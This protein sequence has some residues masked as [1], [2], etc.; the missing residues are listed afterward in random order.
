[1]GKLILIRHGHTPLNAAG[2]EERLRGWLDIPLDEQG[3]QEAV[4][5]AQRIAHYRVT[6]IYS[7]DLRR[8]RQT[9]EIV[10]K[11]TKASVT[12]TD[13]LR[14]WNLGIFAGQKLREIIPFLNQLNQ[15]PDLP[16]PS[17]ESFYEFYG[18]YTR[19][20]TELLNLAEQSSGYVVAVTHVR[21]LLAT[22]TIL[23]H[24][25][26]S[27]VPVSGGPRTG[28]LV[29]VEKEGGTWKMRESAA[30]ATAPLSFDFKSNFEWSH[31]LTVS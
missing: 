26:R 24:G 28:T 14:P 27:R 17:G 6:A 8:A 2:E 16:A 31:E 7:S 19:R 1:M 11:V 5:T 3:L 23:E 25:D 15:N 29:L 10:S 18:R 9:A 4:E 30:P 13:E 22:R 12:T 21:N 20:L